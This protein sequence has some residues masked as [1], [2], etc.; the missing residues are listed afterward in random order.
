MP[1]DQAAGETGPVLTFEGVIIIEWGQPRPG[2]PG[3]PLAGWKTAIFDALNGKPITTV[4][5]IEIHVPANGLVTADLTMFTDRDGK[6]LMELERRPKPGGGWAQV[7]HLRD[8]DMSKGIATGTFPFLVSEMRVR[9]PAPDRA[10][11][12]PK[13]TEPCAS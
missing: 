9:Q 2:H 1:E 6:P 13:F 11:L 3:Q 12:E 5:K 8:G 7:V 4:S 10:A